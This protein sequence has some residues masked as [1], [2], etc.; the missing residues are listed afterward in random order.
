M[1]GTLLYLVA[2]KAKPKIMRYFLQLVEAVINERITD[3]VKLD[4]F[5]RMLEKVEDGDLTAINILGAERVR[6]FP[7]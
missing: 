7:L 4:T 5:I 2:Y 3:A 1:Q 6:I